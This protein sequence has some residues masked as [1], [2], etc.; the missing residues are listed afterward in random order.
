M[1][2][3]L[4]SVVI[5]TYNRAE[6]LRRALDSV[7]R[8][9]TDGRFAYE[10]IVVDDGSTDNTGEV[11]AEVAASSPVPVRYVRE[12]RGGGI[13]VAR[14]TGVTQA[15]GEWIAFFDDDQLAPSHW[16]KDLLA[17]A[18]DQ[19]ARCIGGPRTLDLTPEQLAVLGP[20]RRALLGEEL[21]PERPMMFEGKRLPTTG[22]LLLHREVFDR[23]SLF[24][25]SM[26]FSGED[27]DFL[28]RAQAAGF[29]AW[30]APKA[31]VK[32]MIPDYRLTP[33]YFRWVSRRWG[34]NF[35]KM[36][37]KKR[38]KGKTLLLSVGRIG[39]AVLVTT[40][41][42]ALALLRR[43]QPRLGDL[44]CRLWRTQAHV[45]QTLQL[46]AP[47]LFAQRRFFAQLEFRKER[48]AFASDT[49]AAAKAPR[50]P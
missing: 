8:Q 39:Q 7:I 6:T 12:G 10:V 20:I 47:T 50:R 44:R 4:I 15:G 18:L 13:A 25:T 37:C 11:A 33:D 23:V 32:H 40:P 16:L 24:D 29:A 31:V 17:A 2:E 26:A 46:L 48:Q 38:G 19:D 43:D 9:E 14:N 34:A 42:L 27:S 21:Y 22:N 3:P 45:R 41:A 35:A 1:R 30:T 5:C 36:D 49:D 28:R